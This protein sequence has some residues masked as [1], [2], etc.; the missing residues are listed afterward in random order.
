MSLSIQSLNADSTFLLTFSPAFVPA[1]AVDVPGS[2]RILIDPW[3]S[4]A[5]SVWTPSFQISHHTSPPAI[6][7]LREMPE[8]DLILISQDKPDH[9]H[10][11]TLC[12]LHP[13]SQVR[14]LAVP[15]AAKK[16]RSWK[17][18][19][20]AVIETLDPFDIK[21]QRSMFRIPLASYSSGSAPGEVTIAYMPQKM[22]MT[23]L[24]NAIGITYRPPGRQT[25]APSG[26]V[27]N[28]PFATHESSLPPRIRTPAMERSTPFPSRSA[29]TLSAP[30]SPMEGQQPIF[31]LQE[32][33]L[34]VLYSPHGVSTSTTL[35]YAAYLAEQSALPLTAFFHSINTEE[36]PW[37][38]GGRVVTGY[39]GGAEILR[40]FGARYWISAH[41]EAKDNQGWSVT[42]IKSTKYDLEE[43]QRTLDEELDDAL[44]DE[45]QQ[46]RART[47]VVGMESGEQLR[48]T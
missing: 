7:S 9:C 32:E 21:K 35:P 39:P 1:E 28:L 25:A 10:R 34:S 33:T 24:H 19:K 45:D 37:L 12:T 18:F 48:I 36:N 16:V 47:V 43:V 22:D 40:K 11:E 41:D 30:D 31:P 44:D 3:L 2:F 23:A 38:M 15:A 17:H 8:P 4:G 5:S 13:D 42:W 27:V 46:K 29:Q 6:S 20:K 26:S 14:I